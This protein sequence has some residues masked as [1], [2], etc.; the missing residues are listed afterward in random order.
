MRALCFYGQR[1]IRY[2]EFAEPELQPD[3][4]RLR[5]TDA[6]LSQTQIS[7]FIEG[8]YIISCDTHP[9]TGH[10]GPVIP[11]QEFGGAVVETG[12]G[13]EE[14]WLGEQ[15]AVLPAITC[16]RC[17]A[18]LAGRSNICSKL[19]YRGLLG[20]HG[21]FATHA[22]VRSDQILPIA[23]RDR[24]T[25]LEPLLL[26]IH[27][28]KRMPGG[29]RPGA[30]V[31]ILGAGA[32]GMA[33]AAIWRD[34]FAADIA[35]FDISEARRERAKLTGL[36]VLDCEPTPGDSYEIIVDAAGRTLKREK[37]AFEQAIDLCPPGGTIV[38]LGGYFISLPLMPASFIFTEKAIVPSFAYDSSDVVDFRENE[39]RLTVDFSPLITKLPLERLVEEGY[40]A[41]ELN[42]DAFT[43][44]VA[45][46]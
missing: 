27:A 31:L 20:A 5:V 18:C 36:P 28:A 13:V 30:K 40:Y 32:V 41:A 3:Q 29:L 1:D 23:E 24:L 17:T 21:G 33:I 6:G 39:D 9:L 25:F 7:E 16:G 11:C 15:V 42:S 26:G 4:I 34:L 46:P 2:Q 44:I 22:I 35:L 12:P 45:T 38:V 19:A 14:S 8:P 37:Q 43:R 10:S